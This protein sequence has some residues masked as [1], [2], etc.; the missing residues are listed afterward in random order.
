MSKINQLIQKLR[1]FSDF[2]GDSIEQGIKE[3]RK[4]A[5]ALNLG[6]ML[7][8]KGNDGQDLRP[9]YTEDNFF[10]S[11][12][13]SEA[14][15]RFKQRIT[16]NSKRNPNAPNLTI[17]GHYHSGVRGIDVR[18][19]IELKN[20]TPFGLTVSAKFNKAMGL[21]RFS[22]ESFYDKKLKERLKGDVLGYFKIK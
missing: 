14:Y 6:Q 19:G 20:A 7:D 12:K 3:N 4:E 18:G 11:K 21:S 1:G 2:L 10:K 15:I 16:P 22:V 13:S 9:F 5:V 17:N 8:G